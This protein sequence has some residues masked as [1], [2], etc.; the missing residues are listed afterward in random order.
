MHVANLNGR[1]TLLQDARGLD[2]E[3]AS[4]GRFG[5]DPQ[6]IYDDWDA[7]AGWAS[8]AGFS[9]AGP[10]DEAALGAPVPRPRQVFALGLNY[11]MHA[12]EAGLELPPTTLTFTKFP[13]CLVGPDAV[14]DVATEKVDWEVELVA[15]IGRAAHRVDAADAWS[16]VAGL[17]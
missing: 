15:V 6:A 5:S 7:F 16:H 3:R 14:V 9:G 17:T 12:R 11:A 8:D 10:V 1:L 4:G 2:V 13:S